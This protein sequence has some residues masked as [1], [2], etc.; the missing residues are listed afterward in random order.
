MD[1]AILL[2]LPSITS[3][4]A[5]FAESYRKPAHRHDRLREASGKDRQHSTGA[6][7]K[8]G[9]PAPPPLAEKPHAIT[10]L[11]I[12]DEEDIRE[13]ISLLLVRHGLKVIT[14]AD[15]QSGLELFNRQADQ[16]SVV[17]LDVI[18][19]GISSEQVSRAM[20]AR[21][22]DVRI[23]LSSGYS[24]ENT[25]IACASTPNIEFLQKPY[26]VATLLDKVTAAIASH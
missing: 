23:I 22:P 12:D 5:C 17:L 18:M 14:A 8:V 9:P 4:F 7:H 2:A 20:L 3:L 10:V 21:R 11:V 19:P 25:H 6:I 13:V 1:S 15:G 26:T 24:A 16:I